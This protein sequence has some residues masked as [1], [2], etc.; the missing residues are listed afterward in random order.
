MTARWVHNTGVADA[1]I[2]VADVQ[3]PGHRLEFIQF[4]ASAIRKRNEV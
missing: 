4:L 3:V 2:D 1:D